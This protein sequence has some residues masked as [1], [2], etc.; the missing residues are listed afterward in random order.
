MFVVMAFVFL[1][2]GYVRRAP[3]FPGMAQHPPA[4]GRARMTPSKSWNGL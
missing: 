4:D 2:M 1:S 3:A